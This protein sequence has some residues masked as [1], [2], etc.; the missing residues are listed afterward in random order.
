MEILAIIPARGGSKG[1][2]RKNVRLMNGKPLISY[3]IDNAKACDLITDVVVST[4][5]EEIE[6]IAKLSNIYCIK[7]NNDLSDDNVTLDPVVYDAVKKMEQKNNKSYDIIITLQ[8]TSPLLSVETLNNALKSFLISSKDTYIS[9]VNNPHLSWSSKG[10]KYSPNYRKRLNRQELPPNF[11]ETGAF[12]ITRRKFIT[13]D[14]RMGENVSI[15]EV[16]EKES[17]DIDTKNDWIVCENELKKKRIVFRVDGFKERGMGHIY[18]CLTLAYYLTGHEVMFV[19]NEKHFEGVVKIKNSFMPYT[20]INSD[21]EFFVFLDNWNA[22]IIVNDCLDTEKVYIKKLKQLA[23][24]VIT[25]E[26]LGEGAKYADSV[27]NALYNNT[28]KAPN[29]YYGERYVCLRDEFLINTPKEFSK[30]IKNV[31]VMF[32]GTDP[33]NLTEKIYTWAKSHNNLGGEINFIFITGKGYNSNEHNVHTIENKNIF[34]LNDVKRVSDYMK[35]ADIAFTSQGRTVFELASLGVPSIVLAQN[36]REQL[37]TFAQMQN[38]F[39]NLGLGKDI[40]I[41]TIES[42]FNWLLNSNQIRHEMRELMLRH[43]LKKGID[44]VINLILKEN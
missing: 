1:I 20:L 29:E 8:P 3:S 39:L 5:D 25:I 30:E 28:V 24:K 26:D 21:E 4:D 15:F 33:S 13:P 41:E 43:D 10:D 17:V 12:F 27:I 31:L 9:A 14:S 32:G 2:P 37:H 42:T 40:S 7:R 22:D 38:G 16:P 18:H 36:K 6:S 35:N 23:E 19:L 44:R 11:I 34:V